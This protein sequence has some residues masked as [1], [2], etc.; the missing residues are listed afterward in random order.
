[1]LAVNPANAPT[2][3]SAPPPPAMAAADVPCRT[4]AEFLDRLL[5]DLPAHVPVT[6]YEVFAELEQYQTLCGVALL[7]NADIDRYLA[8]AE[9]VQI[10]HEE[11][12]RDQIALALREVQRCLE[13]QE[14]AEGV[15][16]SQ[17]LLQD[18]DGLGERSILGESWTRERAERDH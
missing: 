4:F 15:E 14:V 11:F 5:A 2:G 9:H 18:G 17:S 7:A 6:L 10:L 1:M 16:R 3:S 13:Q 12:P 8:M